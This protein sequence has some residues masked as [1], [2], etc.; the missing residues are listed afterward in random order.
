MYNESRAYGDDTYYNG[1]TGIV[2]DRI[3]SPG[4]YDDAVM[5]DNEWWLPHRRH[6]KEQALRDELT[7]NG[8]SILFQDG[9]NIIC[10]KN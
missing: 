2:Y 4:Q 7:S 9:G 1:D 6:F 10:K 3:Q 5:I 8:F